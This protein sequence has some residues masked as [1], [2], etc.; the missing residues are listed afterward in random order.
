MY[1]NNTAGRGAGG[2][3]NGLTKRADDD[4]FVSE[5]ADFVA[6]GTH[7]SPQGMTKHGELLLKFFSTDS[8]TR[9]WFNAAK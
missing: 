2:E 7:H 5:Q 4:G 6:D 8:T 9:P 3:A 1:F